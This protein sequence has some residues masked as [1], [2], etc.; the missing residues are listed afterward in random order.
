VVRAKGRVTVS[1]GFNPW[2]GKERRHNI[3]R[4]C[5]RYGG[6]GHPVVGAVSRPES[7]VDEARSIAQA[8]C[9]E[10]RNIS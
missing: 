7:A 1:V 3:A 9:E 4:I 2:A 6:G 8:V 5:E 10:L